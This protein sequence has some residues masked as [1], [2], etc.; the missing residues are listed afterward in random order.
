[1]FFWASVSVSSKDASS[2]IGVWFGFTLIDVE[3]KDLPVSSAVLNTTATS[4]PLTA[5][6][7]SPKSGSAIIERSYW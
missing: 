5:S 3:G 1:M 2:V 7:I 4:R 6:V